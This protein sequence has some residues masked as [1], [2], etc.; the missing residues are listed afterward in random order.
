MFLPGKKSGQLTK[1][2]KKKSLNFVQKI[3]WY[4]LFWVLNV[5][6][7][8][9]KLRTY[10]GNTTDRVRRCPQCPQI[11]SLVSLVSLGSPNFIIISI[12]ENNSGLWDTL[13]W[14]KCYVFCDAM[15]LAFYFFFLLFPSFFSSTPLFLAGLFWSNLNH[16]Q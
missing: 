10:G 15:G 9:K 16:I 7:S 4:D 12:K 5:R 11:L 6:R 14:Q 3:W 13:Y 2:G 8:W 1:F